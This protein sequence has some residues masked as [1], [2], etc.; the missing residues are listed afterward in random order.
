MFL[1]KGETNYVLR[2]GDKLD[3]DYRIDGI[4]DQAVSFVYLPLDARQLLV[5]GSP[6]ALLAAVDRVPD[7]PRP[8]AP[9]APPTHDLTKLVWNAPSRVELGEEFTIEVGLPAGPQPRAGRIELVYDPM[10]LAIL[11]GAESQ[12]SPGPKRRASVEVIG[13]GFVGGQPTPSEV[14][15]RVLAG[16]PTDTQI[17]IENL[18]A[19]A[20]SGA[21]VTVE[22][23]KTYKLAIVQPASR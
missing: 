8:L 21:A 3:R 13:P 22:S 17:G 12:S 1:A 16:T 18:S 7:V 10:V 11:G 2:Q 6:S 14:R 19:V 5:I 4:T 9:N 23:P 20:A 15:F